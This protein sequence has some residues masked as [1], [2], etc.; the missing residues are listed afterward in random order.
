MNENKQQQV[1]E[2]VLRI[3]GEDVPFGS[4]TVTFKTHQGKITGMKE[5]HKDRETSG[6]VPFCLY[7]K[8]IKSIKSNIG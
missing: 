2:E 5:D 6:V 4:F 3:A 8:Y 7:G 1:M